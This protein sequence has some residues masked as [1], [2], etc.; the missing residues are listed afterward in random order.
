MEAL[1]TV[2][3]QYDFSPGGRWKRG[4]QQETRDTLTCHQKAKRGT[5]SPKG[6]REWREQF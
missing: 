1:V 6:K 2:H 3:V 5:L 4:H